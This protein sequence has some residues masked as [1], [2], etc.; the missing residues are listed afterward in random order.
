[1]SDGPVNAVLLRGREPARLEARLARGDPSV[2]AMA[3]GDALMFCTDALGE[4]A[5]DE[6]LV[7]LRAIWS[8]LDDG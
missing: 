3:I 5:V 1:V 2:R 7:A 8:T 6:I 4:D